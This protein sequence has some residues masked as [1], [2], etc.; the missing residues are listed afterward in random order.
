M[1]VASVAFISRVSAGPIRK[2]AKG[3]GAACRSHRQDWLLSAPAIARIVLKS[4]LLQLKRLARS[5]ALVREQA[6]ATGAGATMTHDLSTRRLGGLPGL[7][8][9]SQLLDA[10]ADCLEI[11]SC[12]GP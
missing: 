1:G 8:L 9:P 3:R 5:V 6:P 2:S 11:V 12:S 4:N 7:F 10:D